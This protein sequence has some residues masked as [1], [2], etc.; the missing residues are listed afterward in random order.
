[1]ARISLISLGCEKNLVNSEQML[2]LLAQA[3]H[4]TVEPES[5]DV[6]IVNTCGFID[7]AKSEAIENIL[8]LAAMRERGCSFKIIVA[9]CLAQRYPDEILTQLPEVDGIIGTGSYGEIVQAVNEALGCGLP[10]LMGDIN[11]PLEEIPRLVTTPQWYS[12]LRIAE[13]CDNRCAYCVIPS[14]RGRYRSRSLD[15][16]LDEARQ[17]AQSG[18][19]E[20]LIIAQDVTRYGKDLRDGTNL[21]KLVRELCRIEGIEWLRLHYLYPEEMTDELLDVMAQESKVLHYFDLP[22]QHVNN[23]IL[24]SMN[25]RDTK[26]GL[27]QLL[28][29][30]RARMPDAVLRTSIICGLPGEGDREFEE[31][32][33]FLS[34]HKLQRAGFFAFSPEEGTAAADMPDQVPS[35]IALERVRI[36]EQLQERIMLEYNQSRLGSRLSV[37]CE[38]YDPESGIYCGRSTADSPTIDEQVYFTSERP[39]APGTFVNILAK[40][41]VEGEIHGVCV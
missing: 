5:A 38:L 27:E 32:C 2:W 26:Q 31:L 39:V 33:D 23:K 3:G 36:L 28:G 10:R 9:G 16:V 35:E 18:T 20:L 34:R 22:I 6:V 25:R 24:R 14:L 40:E 17:L 15:A 21:A 29:K 8:A 37:L 4:D 19:K 13:G 11:S 41:L 30:I 12:Y 1:M 7:S